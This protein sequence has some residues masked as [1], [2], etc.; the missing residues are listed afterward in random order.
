MV[1]ESVPQMLTIIT[2]VSK[3]ANNN[4]LLSLHFFYN[5]IEIILFH[6][7]KHF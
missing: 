4:Y 2:V 1:I 7:I 5:Q 6:C 3:Q